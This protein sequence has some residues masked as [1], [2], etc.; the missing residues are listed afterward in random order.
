[1]SAEKKD[2]KT[3]VVAYDAQEEYKAASNL[4][5]STCFSLVQKMTDRLVVVSLV[6]SFTQTSDKLEAETAARKAAQN[7]QPTPLIEIVH[8]VQAESGDYATRFLQLAAEQ[9]ADFIVVGRRSAKGFAS[10]FSTSFSNAVM[11]ASTV[12]VL[13]VP[14]PEPIEEG[15]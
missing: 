15:E 1:M 8:V 4:A 12:P 6:G 14:E 5:L 3:W 7:L 13:I 9:S 2:Q 10:M 11:K